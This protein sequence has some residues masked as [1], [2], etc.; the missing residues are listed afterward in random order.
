MAKAQAQGEAQ[1]LRHLA[2]LHEVLVYLLHERGG[3]PVVDAPQGHDGGGG[4]RQQE[5]P[6]QAHVLGFDLH[7][8]RPVLM[9]MPFICSYRNK[10]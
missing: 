2:A 7:S 1:R 4:A 8:P 3:S 6:R 10:K 9:M 5:A